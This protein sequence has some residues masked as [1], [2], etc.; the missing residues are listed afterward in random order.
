LRDAKSVIVNDQPRLETKLIRP[1]V[2]L[3]I[4]ATAISAA[5]VCAGTGDLDI[6]RLLRELRWK[7]EDVPFG[8]HV[9]ISMSLG[10]LFLGGGRASLRRDDFS[11]ACLLMSFLPRY[12]NRTI[13]NQYHLQALRHFYVL[14]TEYRLLQVEDVDSREQ[15]RVSVCIELRSGEIKI[16]T[17][18]CLLP[19]LSTVKAVHFA[20]KSDDKHLPS[21]LDINARTASH[22]QLTLLLKSRSKEAL[23]ILQRAYS[24]NINQQ[25]AVDDHIDKLTMDFLQRLTYDAV[26]SGS[27]QAEQM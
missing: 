4:A 10:L 19:E 7:T 14:A 20:P 6:M 26:S 16:A 3:S 24:S 5:S 11:I 9:A 15:L 23:P 13:D 17:S 27:T 22:H 2:E 8:S 1:H 12:P 25:R 18:P 21:S